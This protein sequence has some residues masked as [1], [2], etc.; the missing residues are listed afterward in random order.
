LA[1]PHHRL[2]MQLTDPGLGDLQDPTDFLH[3]QP[4][5]IIKGNQQPFTL[6]QALDGPD[7]RRPQLSRFGDVRG[8]FG[9]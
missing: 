1:H 9:V 4:F 2:G 8:R 5:M 7:Q 6:R 3:G